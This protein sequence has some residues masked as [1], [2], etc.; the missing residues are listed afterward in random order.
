MKKKILKEHTTTKNVNEK[1]KRKEKI[2]MNQN[3]LYMRAYIFKNA[4]YFYFFLFLV[5]QVY[6]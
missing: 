3:V 6:E 1:T 5:S 2:I 4:Y